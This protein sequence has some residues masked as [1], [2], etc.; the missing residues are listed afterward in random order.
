M[1]RHP[2]ALVKGSFSEVQR[3][4]QAHGGSCTWKGIVVTGLDKQ[5]TRVFV[6]SGGGDGFCW[7]PRND[8]GGGSSK[9]PRY[10]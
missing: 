3:C 8:P 9:K 5:Q 2:T 10:E 1:G 6:L 4:R 7:S